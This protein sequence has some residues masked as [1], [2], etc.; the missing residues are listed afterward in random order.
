MSNV[1]NNINIDNLPEEVQDAILREFSSL[2]L[3]HKIIVYSKIV[4]GHLFKV[5]S[6]DFFNISKQ[7]PSIVYRSFIKNVQER[8]RGENESR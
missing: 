2:S 1:I 4:H 3:K 5:T 6:N 8:V 7:T